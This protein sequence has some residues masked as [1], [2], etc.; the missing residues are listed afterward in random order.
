MLFVYSRTR[1]SYP[2][3]LHVL[4]S[5]Q[6]RVCSY[7]NI[8]Q[9]RCIRKPHPDS[10]ANKSQVVFQEKTCKIQTRKRA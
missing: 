6:I 9:E 3:T 1:P 10:P 4:F 5:Q 2:P 8:A 7:E